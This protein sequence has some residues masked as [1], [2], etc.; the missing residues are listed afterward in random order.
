MLRGEE[1]YLKWAGG[2]HNGWEGYLLRTVGSRS[3]VLSR[4][5]PSASMDLI[6][7]PCL[8]PCAAGRAGQLGI[9]EQLFQASPAP[10]LITHESL[11]AAYGMAGRPDKVGG[12][13][14]SKGGG[15]WVVLAVWRSRAHPHIH[16]V[17]QCCR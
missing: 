4:Q 13:W 3:D 11:M 15:E 5:V 6:C 2:E 7:S 12:V 14:R 8:C 1:V 16:A 17:V 10:D 9:A